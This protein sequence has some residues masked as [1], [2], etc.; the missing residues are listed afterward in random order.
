M[1]SGFG[2]V[3]S[4]LDLDGKIT[5]LQPGAEGVFEILGKRIIRKIWQ[6][7]KKR[8]FFFYIERLKV[9]LLFRR[10][11]EGIRTNSP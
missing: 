11:K 3:T 5:K 2:S 1:I 8:T 4:S 10:Q 9:F 7:L 6:N